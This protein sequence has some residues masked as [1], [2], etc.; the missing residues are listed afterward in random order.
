MDFSFLKNFKPLWGLLEKKHK[1]RLSVL[2]FFMV[3]A[4]AGQ[5]FAISLVVPFLGFALDPNYI[6]TS[7]VLA[8]LY[9]ELGFEVEQNFILVLGL[10]VIAVVI[11]TNLATL[12]VLAGSSYFVWA[13]NRD[14][15]TQLLKV[16]M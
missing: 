15:S 10:V 6:E 4:A 5:M 3:L 2:L 16:Y 8:A 1:C 12:F 13:L 7:P 9:S 14:I 11:L